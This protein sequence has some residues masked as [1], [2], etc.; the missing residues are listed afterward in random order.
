MENE[1]LKYLLQIRIDS[2]QAALKALDSNLIDNSSD[3]VKILR[4]LQSAQLR[5][6][7]Q[8]QQDLLILIS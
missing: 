5:A 4:E 2:R 6:V 1:K 3:Q 7:I 8:E